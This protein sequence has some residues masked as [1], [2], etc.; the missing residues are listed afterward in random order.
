[1][2]LTERKE[3]T[4]DATISIFDEM[5]SN[6]INN[7]KCTIMSLFVSL[8]FLLSLATPTGWCLGQV[9]TLLMLSGTEVTQAILGHRAVNGHITD[10]SVLA[11]YLAHACVKEDNEKPNSHKLR[12]KN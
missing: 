1:M 10:L 2:L 12:Y 8:L 4:M 5:T 9:A 11:Y 7:Y 3:W 6:K